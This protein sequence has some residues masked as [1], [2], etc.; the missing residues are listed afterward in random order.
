M[1]FFDN[2]VNKYDMSIPEISYKYYH[3]IRVMNYMEVLAKSMNLPIY[4]VELAKIIG[5]LHDIGR[6]EQ[7][8]RYNSFSDK[9][10]DHGD[11]GE[12]VLIEEQALNSFNIKKEDYEVVY[13]AIRNHNK[14]EI[15]PNLNKRTLLFSKMIRDADKLDILF[16]IGN[17]E[18]KSIIYEDDSSIRDRIKDEFF[19][20]KQIKRHND[21]TDNENIIVLFSFIYDFNFKVSID[22]IKHKE[23]Y[24][25]I[26]KRIK[27][28][29]LFK[30][31]I[32]H[33]IEYIEEQTN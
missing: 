32:D 31:Y 19:Q 20:N 16:A 1:D 11:Y 14:Y 2:Y 27:H 3:S 13:I 21:E 26:Y 33:I 12:Q 30:P 24:Q 25:K 29:E 15:E 7:Y 9:N 4:D 17:K 28:T 10:I 5:L 18:I 8:K 22:I 23:Y 6:F